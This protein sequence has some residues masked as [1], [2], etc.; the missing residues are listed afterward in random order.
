MKNKTQKSFKPK[1]QLTKN[2]IRIIDKKASLNKEFSKKE[3][4]IVPFN[5]KEKPISKPAPSVEP[6]TADK[7]QREEFCKSD[8]RFGMIMEI[9]SGERF[10]YHNQYGIGI[11]KKFRMDE[12]QEDLLHKKESFDKFDIMAVYHFPFCRTID[13][14]LNPDT[15]MKSIWERNEEPP[16]ELLTEEEAAKIL[17]NLGYKI[18]G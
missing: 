16:L 7:P 17:E 5:E 13:E 15:K 11:N 6:Q 2:A 10:F 1:S 4:R 14:V 3:T 9:R 8:L 18:K 12:I